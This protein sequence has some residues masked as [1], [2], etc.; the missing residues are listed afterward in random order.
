MCHLR[1]TVTNV[2]AVIPVGVGHLDD[3]LWVTIDVLAG[4]RARRGVEGAA[5]YNVTSPSA[6]RILNDNRRTLHVLS[7]GTARSDF[8]ELCI[9]KYASVY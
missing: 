3:P 4:F 9:D 8:V 7:P 2:G 5:P 1:P 6:I